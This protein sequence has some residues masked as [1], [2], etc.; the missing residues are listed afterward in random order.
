M[1]HR[2]VLFF[3]V[4]RFPDPPVHLVAFS[5]DHRGETTAVRRSDTW[6]TVVPTKAAAVAETSTKT[7]ISLYFKE[8]FITHEVTF[9][10]M[11][12]FKN[13]IVS[14]WRL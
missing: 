13:Y 8:F 10:P 7:I 4:H 3:D 12:I 2:L 11:S 9:Q 1:V 6:W 14:V 5:V